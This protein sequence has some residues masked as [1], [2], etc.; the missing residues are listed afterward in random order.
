MTSFPRLPGALPPGG[1]APGGVPVPGGTA[2]GG[3]PVP[4]GTAPGGVDPAPGGTAPGAVPVPGGT[5]PG[6]VWARAAGD[7]VCSKAITVVNATRHVVRCEVD[8]A[9]TPGARPM[10]CISH[11]EGFGPKGCWSAHEKTP[12]AGGVRSVM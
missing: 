4:G 5:A 7:C 11:A 6:A 8:M 12:P 3:V 1:M 2:P 10:E 9:S